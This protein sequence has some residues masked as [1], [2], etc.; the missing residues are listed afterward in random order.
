[1]RGGQDPGAGPAGALGAVD[2]PNLA[3]RFANCV[4]RVPAAAAEPA[5]REPA[6]VKPGCLVS[7]ALGGIT[8]RRARMGG[9]RPVRVQAEIAERARPLQPPLF[10]FAE[11]AIGRADQCNDVEAARTRTPERVEAPPRLIV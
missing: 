4:V 7:H 9:T 3:H 10:V 11:R 5:R 1:M 8:G 6:L 2:E